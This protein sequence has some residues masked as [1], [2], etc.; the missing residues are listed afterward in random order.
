MFLKAVEGIEDVL[1]DPAPAVY[2]R[3]LGSSAVEMALYFWVDQTRSSLFEA[4][5]SAVQ[6]L[7]EAAADEGINLPYPIQTVRL[8]ELAQ[9]EPL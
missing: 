9:E 2:C 1:Q 4:T 7:K 3:G 6:R 5:S 8:R